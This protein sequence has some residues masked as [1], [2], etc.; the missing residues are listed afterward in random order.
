ML[1]LANLYGHV[2]DK[3]I[4]QIS[5]INEIT[6]QLRLAHFLAQCGH[7]SVNFSI[8]FENCNYHADAL[9]RIFKKHFTHE[10]A[11][12]YARNPTAIANRVYANRMGN[13]NEASGDGH[14]Y[15]GRGISN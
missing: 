3:A 15:R 8:V 10:Q 4:D 6:N 5:S 7:E 13:G 2:P 12:S 14:K 1:K 11:V 9:E